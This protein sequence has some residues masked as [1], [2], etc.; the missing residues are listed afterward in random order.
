MNQCLLQCE[1]SFIF[2]I[3]VSYSSK[4]FV[5]WQ[6]ERRDKVREVLARG[7]HWFP[8]NKLLLMACDD[9]LCSV[10]RRGLHFHYFFLEL[11]KSL[12][13]QSPCT[14]YWCLL[15]CLWLKTQ[16]VYEKRQCIHS[17]GKKSRVNSSCSFLCHTSEQG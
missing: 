2:I 5:S 8:M 6:R 13:L 14:D 4:Q 16:A 3:W 17:G 12:L 1:I 10:Q 9:E 15:T 11:V 7:L